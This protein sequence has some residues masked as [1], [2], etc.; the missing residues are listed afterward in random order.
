MVPDGFRDIAD[1]PVEGFREPDDQ[2]ELWIATFG[3]E[4]GRIPPQGP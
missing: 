2:V 1:V 3:H 4:F